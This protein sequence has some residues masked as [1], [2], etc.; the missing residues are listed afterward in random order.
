MTFVMTLKT[1]SPTLTQ[2]V[3]QTSRRCTQRI[4]WPIVPLM[5]HR[6]CVMRYNLCSFYV[7][8]VKEPS[9]CKP[10]P[11]EASHDFFEGACVAKRTLLSPWLDQLFCPIVTGRSRMEMAACLVLA[12]QYA[13]YLVD[14]SALYTCTSCHAYSCA[15]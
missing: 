9:G 3:D 10:Y 4:G 6:Q 12:K 11:L 14:A 2:A 1:A 7:Y 8:A 15:M 5:C 13:T